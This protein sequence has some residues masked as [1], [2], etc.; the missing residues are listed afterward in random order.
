L[1]GASA[2][3]QT[4][5]CHDVEAGRYRF[6]CYVGDRL[7]GALFLAPEPV[8]VSR[9]WAVEQL[10]SIHSG[11][12]SR[13][14]VIAGRPGKGAPDRGATVCSC[15]GVGANDIAAAVARGCTTVAAIGEALQ[16]GT[17]CGSCRGEIRTIIDAQGAPPA[18]PLAGPPALV[19]VV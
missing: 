3:A 17:S 9:A 16:A 2:S 15:F 18:E 6:A 1:F 4:I 10:T 19:A 8:A 7:V 12:R 5:A 13:F 11:H 14:A